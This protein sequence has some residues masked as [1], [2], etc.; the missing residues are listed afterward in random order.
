MSLDRLHKVMAEAG[1]GSRRHCEQM[2]LD[3]KVMVDG[4]VVRELG[5]K[6]D[7]E[8]NEIICEGIVLRPEKRIYIVMNKPRGVVCTN[9]DPSGRPRVVDLLHRVI[10]RIFP[11]GRLDVDSEGLLVVT[12]DGEL[13]NRLT[14]PRYEVPKTYF[15]VVRGTMTPESVKK[16]ET[17]VWLSEGKSAPAQVKVQRRT[18]SST[19]LEISLKE[20]KNREVRRILAKV[21]HA[22][23]LLRRV[24]IGGLTLGE[25][26]P[27]QHRTVT[28]EQLIKMLGID[29]S[30]PLPP[31]PRRA[32][33]PQ[34]RVHHGKR[35][36]S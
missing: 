21:G 33:R 36:G 27:G 9:K 19:A 32:G 25:L 24:R 8:V 34:S 35:P 11:V 15:V 29:E 2:I 14:H 10:Q 26:R 4:E 6:V 17:G 1:I 23:S 28:R 7:P 18:R 3:R 22:V 5:T 13:C 31:L 30:A 20:G 12:N 16:L